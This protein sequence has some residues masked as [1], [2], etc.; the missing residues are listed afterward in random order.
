MSLGSR[1]NEIRKSKKISLDEL[2]ASSGVPKGTLSKITAG[3]TNNPS[4]ETVKA[5]ASALGC[6]L[7]DLD[8]SRPMPS[9]SLSVEEAEHIKKYRTLD[10]FGKKAVDSILSIE[11]ERTESEPEQAEPIQTKVIPLFGDSFAAGT[12]E[13][14]FGNLWSDYEV[15]ADSKAD[16]AVRIVGKSMEPYL[17]DGSIAL[18]IR[19]APKD[20]EVVAVQI[21]GDSVCKQFCEDPFGNFYFFTLNRD[22]PDIKVMRTGGQNVVGVGVIMID[23][24]LPTLPTELNEE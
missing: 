12:G 6:K 14:S 9:S 16:F 11:S 19:R 15:P 8:D 10:E 13:P 17:M 5:I 21:D 4:L 3:I 2:V 22:Y 24:P 1:I 20:G 18:G 23:R 7:D